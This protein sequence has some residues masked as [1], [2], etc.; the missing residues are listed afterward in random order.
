MDA[1]FHRWAQ[2]NSDCCF[3]ESE[4]LLVRSITIT[5]YDYEHDRV[6]AGAGRLVF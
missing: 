5:N 1:D 6:I 2:M 4:S 3:D